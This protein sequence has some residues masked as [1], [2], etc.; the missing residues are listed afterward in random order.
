M[1]PELIYTLIG[2]FFIFF[3]GI[4]TYSHQRRS[5]SSLLFFLI[6]WVTVF[7]A[8]A[9]YAST[10]LTFSHPEV[11][12]RLVLF[13]AAPHSLLLL[14]F[15]LNFPYE[16]LIVPKKWLYWILG[17]MALA[18][19]AA[20]SPYVFTSAEVI[21]GRVVPTPGFL[22]PF[23]ALIIMSSL[24]LSFTIM[25]RKYFKAD[26]LL[27]VQWRF[28]ILGVFSSY[29]FLIFTNFILVTFF[30][31][32]F[33]VNFAP[34]FMLPYFFGTAYA[35]V[36]HRLLNVK[37]I[38]TEVMVFL[39]IGVS[40]FEIFISDNFTELILRIAGFLVLFIFSTF[41]IQNVLREVEERE[42]YEMVTKELAN[43]ND[44]LEKANRLKS[45]FVSFAS[46]QLKSPLAV[47]KGYADL[48]ADGSYGVA[49]QG[50]YDTAVKIKNAA[51]RLVV[52]LDDFLNIKRIEEGTLEYTFEERNLVE[53][54][55]NIV[56]D[57][58]PIAKEKGL[59]LQF[60]STAQELKAKIDTS[61]MR[62]VIQ[63]LLDNSVK[64]TDRGY[65]NVSVGRDGDHILII[66]TDTGRGISPEFIPKLFERFHREM[67]TGKRQVEGSGLGLF[68]AKQ[69]VSG[70]HGDV[71]AESPGEGK[72]STFYI[73]LP[74]SV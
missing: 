46:H 52:L 73:R 11:I 3:T 44:E 74:L 72:G 55:K 1:T 38:T 66:I 24:L 36:R 54:V 64:Y 59:D 28:M 15:V 42:R 13:F 39:I 22:M 43:A 4:I 65:I 31:N 41:L 51:N 20:A 17:L 8:A 21:D 34:L 2:S 70:H 49:P 62:Q 71:R 37:T 61:K 45:E 40:L 27:K 23:Y 48:I 25:I 68:I 14:L 63:N 67:A 33:F 16:K 19:A 6:S 56:S 60:A 9:N 26:S 57:Y 12:I 58:G 32:T 30:K 50:V 47:I 29:F 5:A 10:N 69:I 18:M 7:W 53:F 35:I